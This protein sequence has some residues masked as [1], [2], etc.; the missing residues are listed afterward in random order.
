MI[1]LNKIFK[2]PGP[3]DLGMSDSNN[4]MPIACFSND[5]SATWEDYYAKV[6]KEYPIKYFIAATFI[7]CFV[8]LFQ[9]NKRRIQEFIY[10]IKCNYFNKY[11]YH[12]LDLRQRKNITYVNNGITKSIKNPDYY[13]YGW[14]DVD[15]RML[16]AIFGLLNSFVENELNTIKVS[17]NDVQTNPFLAKQKVAQDEIL[18]IY[19]WWNNDRFV[20][21]EEINKLRYK[22][23][24]LSKLKRINAKQRALN[25]LMIKEKEFE[26]KTD[27][28]VE[29]L[30]KVRRTLW[31]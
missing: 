21:M 5:E 31:S 22:W 16:Y 23:S 24:S 18:S 15:D 26:D 6:K 1:Y 20:E 25:Q 29:K 2:I 14:L 12:M 13:Q 8:S 28:M 17:E 9:R 7:G 11:K 19:N 10:W 27:E 3:K 4:A 30:M